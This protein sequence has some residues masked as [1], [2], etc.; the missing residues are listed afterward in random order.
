MNSRIRVLHIIK[1]LGRGGAE[2]LLPETLKLHSKDDFE[3]HCIYFLPWKN[4][5]VGAIESAGGKVTCI[6]SGNNL[7]MLLNVFKVVRYVRRHRIQLIHAHLPWAG[8]VARLVFILTRVPTVY[9]EHNKQERYHG[10]TAWV[11]KLTFNWQTAAIAVSEDVGLSIRKNIRVRIPVSTILN[12]VNVDA[13][14]RSDY[15]GHLLKSELGLPHDAIIVGTISVFRFQKR[16]TEWLEVAAE[17]S[18]QFPH[19]FFVIVGDGPLKNEVVARR[20]ELGLEK[21]VLMP[22]LQEEVRPWL[23]LMD[24]YMMSSVF[25]GLP[26]ALLEA[27]SMQCAVVST[28][29]GGVKEVVRD[30]EDGLL[31]PVDEWK[32]LARRCSELI[33]SSQRRAFLSQAARNRVM[34]QFSVGRMVTHLEEQYRLV[35]LPSEMLKRSP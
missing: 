9:T 5:L 33:V 20:A 34:D 14:D 28:D 25:E 23:S 15:Q 27:M 10:V 13:F 3:F 26:I 12:G 18:K 21:K 11:N 4:Q 35:A 6:P 31:V 19:V 7:I 32:Q 1:S 8:I 22:G 24:I 2:T 29:A 16:L 17:I 30:G